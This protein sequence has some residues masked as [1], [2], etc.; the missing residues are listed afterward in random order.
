MATK[1]HNH[2][3]FGDCFVVAH[4]RCKQKGL[5]AHRPFDGVTHKR[6][7]LQLSGDRAGVLLIE[8]WPR[9]GKALHR[10]SLSVYLHQTPTF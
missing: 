9:E 3:A 7:A 4:M 6:I 2:G 1:Q 10:F 5:A 8:P